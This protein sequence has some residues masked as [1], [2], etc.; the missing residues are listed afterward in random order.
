MVKL[1]LRLPKNSEGYSLE[2]L[3]YCHGFSSHIF[4]SFSSMRLSTKKTGQDKCNFRKK[5]NE[6]N[7]QSQLPNLKVNYSI[8][9]VS[10]TTDKSDISVQI[11]SVKAGKW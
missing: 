3:C 11:P 6:R 4:G 8:S 1:H 5:K 10:F 9:T 2:I 7:H